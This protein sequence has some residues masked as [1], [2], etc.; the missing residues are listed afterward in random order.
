METTRCYGF[1]AGT[2]SIAIA[3]GGSTNGWSLYT[4][5]KVGQSRIEQTVAMARQQRTYTGSISTSA[6]APSEASRQR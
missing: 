3:Q 5:E 2:W 1:G 4:K 6:R